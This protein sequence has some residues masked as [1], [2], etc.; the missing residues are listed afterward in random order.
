M[1][2][3]CAPP[4]II[5]ISPYCAPPS[6]IK[7]PPHCVPPRFIKMPP[8]C[9]PPSYIKMLPYF[10]RPRFVKMPPYWAPPSYNK[11]PPY[12]APRSYIKIPPYCIA[13]SEDIKAQPKHS[14]GV[15]SFFCHVL[16]H[17]TYHHFLYL[18]SDALPC[19]QPRGNFKLVK[20]FFF[21]INIFYHYFLHHLIHLSLLLFLLKDLQ[22]G[23]PS[24]KSREPY[25]V[26]HYWFST[27]GVQIGKFDSIFKFCVQRSQKC[28]P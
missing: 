8:Y 28:R 20:F 14:N 6:C 12:C 5:K 18:R 7:M 3:Y 23:L 16:K 13:V 15:T 21:P 1:P 19:F 11:M 24:A 10:A 2:P 9:A 26:N 4:S 25:H 27:L 22:F 17:F